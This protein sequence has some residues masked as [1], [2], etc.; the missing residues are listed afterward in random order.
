MLS[1]PEINFKR[2]PVTLIIAAVAVALELV[3][4]FEPARR[5]YYYVELKLGIFSS[6]W[7]GELWRPFTSTLLHGG[8]IHAAFNVYW[9]VIFGPALENRFGSWRTFGL[10]VLLGYMSMLPEFIVSNYNQPVDRQIPIVGLSGIIYG[11]FGM[12]WIGRRWRG[13]LEA[14]CDDNTTRI[15][16]GWFV[17]C[18]V[19]SYLNIMP[20]ANVAHGAGFV[21]GVL[22]G[23]VAFDARRRRR[24]TALAAVATAL[25]LSTLIACP[26]HNGYEHVKRRRQ[27]ERMLQ[28]L[29]QSPVVEKQTDQ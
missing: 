11:L 5:D 26:G 7:D 29:P 28:Q 1:P 2:T 27:V 18:I 24:W 15:L 14:V 23:L 21:F 10:I 16:G 13:E 3:C 25:V 8:L 9:L 22:Y 6:I 17:L 12:L 4:T 20:V 19:L